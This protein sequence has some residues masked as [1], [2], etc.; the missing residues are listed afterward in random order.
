MFKSYRWTHYF[1]L[2]LFLTTLSYSQTAVTSLHGIIYD[3]QGSVIPGPTIVISRQDT[4]FSQEHK[5]DHRGEYAFEQI[6]PGKYSVRVTADGFGIQTQYVELLVNQPSTVDFK[7][8]LTAQESVAVD[9]TAPLLNI[10][11]ATIGKPFDTDEIQALPFEGNNIFDLL[12]L[13]PGV[14]FLGDQNTTSTDTRAGAVN[15]ARS[16]QNNITLDG[17]DNNVAT[18]GYAFS[19]ALRATRD[20]V[21][22]FRVVTSNSNAD[23]GRSSGAQISLVTRSGTNEYHGSAYEYN[24]PTNT[25]ANDWF[26]KQAQLTSHQANRPPK[27]LRNV[28]GASFGAPIKRD[29]LFFFGAYEGVKLAEDATVTN[30]VPSPTLVAGKLSYTNAAGGTTTLGP[31]DLAKIDPKCSS[32]GA[33]P[34]GPGVN[35]AALA[36]FA[37]YPGANSASEGDGFNLAAFTFASPNPVSNTTLIVKLDYNVTSVHRLFVRGDLQDDN[38]LSPLQFPGDAATS[39]MFDNTKGIAAGDV[40]TVSPTLINNLRYGFTRPGVAN[41]GDITGPYVSFDNISALQ[42]TTSSSIAIT[43]LHNVIDDLTWVKKHHTLQFGANYRAVFDDHSTNATVFDHAGVG[44]GNLVI[45]SIAN[46]GTSL[47][48]GAFGYPKVST[49]FAS[50]YDAAV[51]DITGLIT[52]A[53]G[54]ANY[55]I[56]NDTLTALPAG[57]VPTRHFFSNEVEYYAQDSW[58]VRP[59]LILNFG[60]RHTLLQV[61]YERDGQQVVPS[62][63]LTKWFENRAAAAAEGQTNQPPV[64]FTEGGQANGKAAYW[65]MD[66]FDFSPRFGFAYSPW[67]SISIRGGYGMYYDHFGSPLVDALDQRGSF[68]L[69]ST[70]SNGASQFVDSAPRFSTLSTVP[71][72]LVP[73]IPAP[74]AFPIT[75]PN[76]L[77][78]AWVADDHIKTPYS[79][80]FDLSV[81]QQLKK[82]FVFEVA[83]TGRLGRR[84]LQQLDLAEPLNVVDPKSGESWYAAA[85]E[86]SKE[87]DQGLTA[88]QIPTSAYFDDM[89]PL[90]AANGKTPTQNI[91]PAYAK[92]RGNETAELFNLDT[93][94]TPGSPAGVTY[95]YFNPQY[96]NLVGFTSIGTSSYHSLQ[97][98][99]HHPLAHGVRFD[100]SYTFSKSIDL[101]SDAE[102][103]APANSRGYSQILN[104]FNIKLN[105]SVS[106][107]D[108]RHNITANFIADLPFGRGMALA[109]NSNSLVNHVIG[110]WTLTS[111]VHATSGLP[112]AALDG[113]GWSTN[114][115]VRSWMVATAPIKSGGHKM[116]SGGYPNVFA[117]PT[118]AVA[119]LRYPYPGEA[120]QRNFFRG[121]GYYSLDSGLAKVIPVCERQQLKFAWEVFNTTNTPMFDPKS[122]SNKPSS[123]ASFGRY[124]SQYTSAGIAARRMQFSLRYSF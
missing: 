121:D 17:V 71:M 19:G 113:I 102:R 10:T 85:T 21:E 119:A 75:P 86:L 112:F 58:M 122:V 89:F 47:D 73:P 101:G 12:S 39:Q 41:R 5:A 11:D 88:T 74:G 37:K 60:V 110:R 116:D 107:Y 81:Q 106:D 56:T 62:F 46:Q 42:P 22:E 32:T 108:A 48:P 115:D 59:N 49:K 103:V 104:S 82:E 93:A 38:S 31:T 69:S 57:L 109:S 66:K 2:L 33:C 118:A 100:I 30:E 24:R 9:A 25:V 99:L 94:L 120:G 68:G 6:P 79:H 67:P 54:Y 55:G 61:P 51:S 16:D 70:L 117:D 111:V 123:A 72:S 13:Q 76:S 91:Y 98:S 80:V 34:L 20:S 29:K 90:A 3:P 65:N 27:E 78:T 8:T 63:S 35:P 43:P 36:Y 28:Y 18:K 15:G 7:M 77:L 114:F 87:V 1:F 124:T 92:L 83:Y 105:K 44:P 14:L 50:S 40:W 97:A 52:S 96:V 26:N 23:A 95:R 64:S 84:L 53:T 45:G 4:G